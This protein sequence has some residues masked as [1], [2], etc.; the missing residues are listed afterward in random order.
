MRFDDAP[1]CVGMLLNATVRP[2]GGACVCDRQLSGA[3][4]AAST[5]TNPATCSRSRLCRLWY[6]QRAWHR[7]KRRTGALMLHEHAVQV[8]RTTRPTLVAAATACG[9]RT[10]QASTA[11]EC[12]LHRRRRR[13]PDQRWRQRERQSRARGKLCCVDDGGVHQHDGG[14]TNGDNVERARRASPA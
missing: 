11:T 3:S 8:C 6:D 5:R 10:K 2:R 1:M 13:R 9:T 12:A 4:A 7:A 14:R